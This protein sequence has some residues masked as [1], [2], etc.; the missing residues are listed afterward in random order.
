MNIFITVHGD[1]VAADWLWGAEQIPA[2]EVERLKALA[3]QRYGMG[4]A[5]TDPAGLVRLGYN[6][7]REPS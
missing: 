3:R 6:I 7:D 1:I 4:I 5:S 2:R